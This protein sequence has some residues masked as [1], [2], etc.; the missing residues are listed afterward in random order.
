MDVT[1]LHI[2]PLLAWAF[3]P[4]NDPIRKDQTMTKLRKT[5]TTG[6]FM[7]FFFNRNTTMNLRGHGHSCSVTL[8]W[9]TDGKVGFPAFADTYKAV[10]EQ[11]TDL[12]ADPFRDHTNEDVA[13]FLWSELEGWSHPVIEKWGGQFHLAKLVL[14]VLGVPDDIGHA[15]GWAFYTIEEERPCPSA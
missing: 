12:L 9:E 10:Q 15:D 3:D 14:G 4:A 8:E 13:D 2:G 1:C 6:P 11:V 5:I 7:G